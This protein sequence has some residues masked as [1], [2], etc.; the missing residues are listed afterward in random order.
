MTHDPLH[1]NKITQFKQLTNVTEDELATRYLNECNW[2]CEAAVGLWYQSNESM[3]V[4]VEPRERVSSGN[5][6]YGLIL[7]I[8]FLRQVKSLL[9]KCGRCI[10]ALYS[11]LQRLV[12]IFVSLI[13]GIVEAF[14]RRGRRRSRH[15]QTTN[16]PQCYE[17]F[18]NRYGNDA[19]MVFQCS[20]FAHIRSL[21]LQT[22]QC[23]MVYFHNQ[24]PV[25]LNASDL[26]VRNILSDEHVV[27]YLT[28][29][30]IS[31]MADLRFTE[32]AQLFQQVM[33]YERGLTESD[34]EGVDG[35]WVAMLSVNPRSNAVV[36][37]D[38]VVI[39]PKKMLGMEFRMNVLDSALHK[40]RELQITWQQEQDEANA[41]R[42]L[43]LQQE[44][45][46]ERELRE[47][48]RREKERERGKEKD[49]RDDEKYNSDDKDNDK[50]SKDDEDSET[51]MKSIRR[52]ENA[53]T[54]LTPEP[55]FVDVSRCV[56]I[57]I[58]LPNGKKIER[59]FQR[60]DPIEQIFYFVETH[61]LRDA[62]GLFIEHWELIR[63]LP[64]LHKY[65]KSKSTLQQ[66]GITFPVNLFV[67][68]VF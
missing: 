40:W 13:R 46:Y 5:W 58:N 14:V 55:S 9:C 24:S 12:E 20:T 65:Q 50:D 17:Q 37:L 64:D 60:T 3:K 23:I 53:K 1:E 57:R 22:Q 39:E 59:L 38:S 66:L 45:E 44:E 18:V 15:G 32:S 25:D 2:D 16:Y 49:R 61:E 56:K 21:A 33:L 68:Q 42:L 6:M 41:S 19:T 34:V 51:K 62:N 31:W 52:I 7:R 67:Q 30:F 8:P 26:F 27:Q 29:N 28:D 35:V 48:T 11:I 47:E 4:A 10:K 63:T 54:K 36:I 43:R